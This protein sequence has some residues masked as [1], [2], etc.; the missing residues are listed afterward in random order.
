[1]RDVG[2]IMELVVRNSA[3][4]AAVAEIFLFTLPT[5]L[6][7][8]IPMGVLVGVLLG[9]S[10]LAA[11]SEITAMRATGMG[12]W[13]FVRIVAIFAVVGWGLALFNNVYL[14]PHSAASLARLQDRLKTSQASFEIQP[15]VF[16]ED[17]KNYVL[18]VQDVTAARGAAEWKGIFLADISTPGQPKVT[19]AQSGL[20]TQ[21][22]ESELRLDLQNGE[23]HSLVENRAGQYEITTFSQSDVLLQLPTATQ[24]QRE[25]VPTAE[26]STPE[27]LRLSHDREPA[28]ARWYLVEYHRRLALPAACIVLALVGIPLGL[29][30]RK[31]GKSTGFILTIGLV[32]LYYFI[33]LLGVSL[34]RQ[35]KLPPGIGVWL[36]NTIFVITGAVLLF[37]ADK[38]PLDAGGWL[39]SE[40]AHLRAWLRR[41]WR[42]R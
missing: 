8:T 21:Q 18:Y 23:Q 31:G 22:G 15:R 30:A 32:F 36:A 38:R 41:K 25:T 33:S 28:K 39:R 5:A 35:G 26:V 13:H 4:A 10:R 6:T 12:A 29:S 40:M 17:F 14:A 20:V 9:L 27:L 34:G 24:P 11:D 1:M 3:P 19:L 16:Y 37:H 42:S 7:I 2:R